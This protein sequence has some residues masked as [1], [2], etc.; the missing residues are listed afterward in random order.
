MKQWDY[1]LRED[2]SYAETIDKLNKPM[3]LCTK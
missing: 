1:T 2:V 3:P